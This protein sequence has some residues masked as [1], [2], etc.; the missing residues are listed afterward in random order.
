MMKYEKPVVLANEELAEGVY[1]ASGSD[2]YTTTAYIVQKPELGR[3]N[4]SLQV[5]AHHDTASNPH[6]GTGQVLT[7]NF[8]LP[9]EF[10]SADGSLV[11]GNGTTTI[12]ISYT[13]HVN[14]GPE[15]HGLGNIYVIADQGLEVVSASLSCNATCAEHAGLF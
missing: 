12:K 9:V 7:L 5:D 4:Y 13:Y 10:V 3:G 14:Q 8:N 11:S 2:C 6:H 1:A 15:N